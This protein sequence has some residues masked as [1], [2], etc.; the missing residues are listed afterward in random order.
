MTKFVDGCEDCQKQG[1]KVTVA[2]VLHHWRGS[3]CFGDSIRTKDG[4]MGAVCG[5]NEAGK[6][7]VILDDRFAKPRKIETTPT[8]IF[9]G[10]WPNEQFHESQEGKPTV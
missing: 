9:P 8:E 4:K 5:K 7:I 10:W 1:R 3:I 6:M 2:S